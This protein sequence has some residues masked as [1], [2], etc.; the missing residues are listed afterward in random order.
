VNKA[1]GVSRV[2]QEP[3]TIDE[4]RGVSRRRVLA[5]A[6]GVGAA[7]ALGTTLAFAQ[8]ATPTPGTGTPE[9]GTS[10]TPADLLQQV[11][12][13]IAA[14]KQDRDAV[15]GKTDLTTVDKLLTQASALSDRAQTAAGGT[16]DAQTLRLARAAVATARAAGDLIEAQLAAYGLPSQKAP[17]SRVL[18]NAYDQIQQLTSNVGT[19]QDTDAKNSIATAQALYKTAYDLY[20]AGTYAGAAAT[21][22]V[23]VK[24]GEL[25]ELLTSQGAFG[26]GGERGGRGGFDGRGQPGGHN[27][28]GQGDQDSSTPTEVPAPTF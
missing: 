12:N 28:D 6:A 23:A 9:A 16:D 2:N 26:R 8:E 5:G 3:S 13:A 10:A 11:D 1:K 7:A 24:V 18:A 25:A 21:A 15:S 27:R 14:A 19:S 20:N 22:R 4:R 17:A